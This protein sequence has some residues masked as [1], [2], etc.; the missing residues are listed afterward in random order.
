MTVVSKRIA[1][2]QDRLLIDFMA[3]A[4]QA[5]VK[6]IARAVVR[7][8][9]KRPS[10]LTACRT[11]LAVH[12]G[13]DNAGLVPDPDGTLL[14]AILETQVLESLALTDQAE[15]FVEDALD[16][17]EAALDA[18]AKLAP[19]RHAEGATWQLESVHTF[20]TSGRPGDAPLSPDHSDQQSVAMRVQQRARKQARMARN[21]EDLSQ[22]E[23]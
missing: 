12:F 18:A 8:S 7:E 20:L 22:I 3:N 17:I 5:E 9:L 13:R 19:A 21:R 6:K 14:I 1:S 15:F 11:W 2:V 16:S 23:V 10:L 4:Q